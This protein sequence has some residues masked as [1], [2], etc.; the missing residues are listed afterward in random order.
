VTAI[1]P[2]TRD[3][4][5]WVVTSPSGLVLEFFTRRNVEKAAAAGWRI[6]TASDYLHR[7]NREIQEGKH[8][9]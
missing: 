4:N 3:C 1:P 2:L 5:S 9:E 8:C 6:E 7:I